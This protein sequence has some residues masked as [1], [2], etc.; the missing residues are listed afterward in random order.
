M[1][2]RYICSTAVYNSLEYKLENSI[3]FLL[4]YIFFSLSVRPFRCSTAKSYFKT[5]KNICLIHC[6]FVVDSML[7]REG[8][9]DQIFPKSWHCQIWVDPSAS[10]YYISLSLGFE[11][12]TY[13]SKYQYQRNHLVG[14]L[15]R[16]PPPPL[17]LILASC[18]IWPIKAL[19]YVTRDILTK[20]RKQFLRVKMLKKCG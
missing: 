11:L 17:P 7:L 6:M 4:C 14:R 19:I 9:G 13:T 1:F 20:V 16:L 5:L 8:L 12:L 18:R 10:L 2:S 15:T 3:Q